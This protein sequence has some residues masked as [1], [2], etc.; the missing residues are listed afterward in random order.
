MNVL[1]TSYSESEMMA[2]GIKEDS[3]F[4]KYWI[5]GQNKALRMYK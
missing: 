2:Y 3:A 5:M 4:G 1:E